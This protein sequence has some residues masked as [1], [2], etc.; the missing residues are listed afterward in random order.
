MTHLQFLLDKQ[1]WAKKCLAIPQ[2][3]YT[4][5]RPYDEFM[6]DVFAELEAV[7]DELIDYV[8]VTLND[9]NQWVSCY[10]DNE[11]V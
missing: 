2:S 3:E 9:N 6:E 1:Q 5:A 8:G 11:S 7:E 4:F 10:I